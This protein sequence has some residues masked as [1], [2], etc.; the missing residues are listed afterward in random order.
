MSHKSKEF[1]ELRA[2]WYAKAAKSG[3]EDIERDED[4]LKAWHSFDFIRNTR[5]KYHPVVFQATEEYYR[6]AGQF[7]HDH[8]FKTKLEYAVWEMHCEGATIVDT[9]TALKSRNF[10][11][12]KNKVNRIIQS[13]AKVMV[14]NA[15]GKK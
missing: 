4:S 10:K 12:H 7:L 13:L 1:L 6:L 11:C 5:N 15:L 9:A 2:K 8:K 3:F 14:E